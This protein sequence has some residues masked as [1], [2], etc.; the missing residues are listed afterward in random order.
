VGKLCPAEQ[1]TDDNMA[2]AHCRL[3]I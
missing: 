2:Y 1:A 3:G